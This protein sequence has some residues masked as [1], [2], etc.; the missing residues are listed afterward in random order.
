[1]TILGGNY[2]YTNDDPKRPA[3]NCL[4]IDHRDFMDSARFDAQEEVEND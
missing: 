1:M 4:A 3:L 2:G